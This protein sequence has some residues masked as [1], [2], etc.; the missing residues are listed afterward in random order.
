[1]K[2]SSLK[3]SPISSN[4]QN[5]HQNWWQKKHKI[6]WNYCH[7]KWWNFRHLKTH[8]FLQI[9]KIFTEIGDNFGENSIENSNHQ[10][11]HQNWWK[12]WRKFN[13]KW[14]WSPTSCI[15]SNHSRSV[16]LRV[17]LLLIIYNPINTDA[18][19]QKKEKRLNTEISSRSEAR[20]MHVTQKFQQPF[21][22]LIS[23]QCFM[24]LNIFFFPLV[25]MYISSH[26]ESQSS[27]KGLIIRLLH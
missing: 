18:L 2:F 12:I 20:N 19:G 14:M 10:N 17:P 27:V 8:Q 25:R 3:N 16:Y 11:F 7:Q 24:S 23:F 26:W 6:G 9:T 21:I 22:C 13:R 15:C 5:L 1:M 4:H